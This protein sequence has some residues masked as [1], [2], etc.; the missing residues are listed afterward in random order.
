MALNKASTEVI[1]LRKL[2]FGIGFPIIRALILIST[3]RHHDRSN[4]I[5][6]FKYQVLSGE[7]YYCLYSNIANDSKYFYRR[8][9]A[10]TA[11]KGYEG[12]RT[13]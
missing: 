10:G 9:T 5:T 7:N 2:L 4:E 8:I 6:R 12:V 13:R 3:P 1:S 11:H